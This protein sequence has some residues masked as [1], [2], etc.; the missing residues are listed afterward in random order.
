MMLKI[1]IV[2]T[3]VALASL[4]CTAA[5]AAGQ[6]NGNDKTLRQTPFV[7]GEKSSMAAAAEPKAG[8]PAAS[9]AKAAGK[10]PETSPLIAVKSPRGTTTVSHGDDPAPGKESK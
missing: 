4:A 9:P 8:K 6:A 3:G 2:A 7:L 1:A 5:L 10:A